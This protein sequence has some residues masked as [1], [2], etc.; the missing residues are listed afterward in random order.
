VT[1]V[2]GP[3]R[4]AAVNAGR[5]GYR[6]KGEVLA[7]ADDGAVTAARLAIPPRAPYGRVEV[8]DAHGRTAWT[9]PLWT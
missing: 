4:G 6:Y 9:N 3:G 7:H 8:Q 1:L 5:L 2:T